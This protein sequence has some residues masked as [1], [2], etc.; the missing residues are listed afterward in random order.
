MDILLERWSAERG[1]DDTVRTPIF[2]F[3]HLLFI[4]IYLSIYLSIYLPISFYISIY[5]YLYTYIQKDILRE[6]WSA[7]RGL[8]DTVRTLTL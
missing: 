8:D 2:I 5:L 1:R 6:R 7:E 4:H 3:V